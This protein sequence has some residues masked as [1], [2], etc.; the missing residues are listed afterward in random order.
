MQNTVKNP[1]KASNFLHWFDFTDADL[2]TFAFI[3]N[4][5][6]GIGLVVYLFLHLIVLSQLAQGASA[7]NSFIA[8]AHSPL[9]VAGEFVVV[10]GV[11]LHGLNG[12]RIALTSLGIG[13]PIQKGLFLGLMAIA[14]VGI[15]IFAIKMFGGA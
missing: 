2:G 12:L 10:A 6:A 7:Y 14:V 15:I 1:R 4:R 11:L 13:V 3:M 8:L 5:I 9:F